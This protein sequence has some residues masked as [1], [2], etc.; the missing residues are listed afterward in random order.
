MPS[1]GSKTAVLDTSPPA[2]DV[3]RR[4]NLPSSLLAS[5]GTSAR[6]GARPQATAGMSRRAAGS[7]TTASRSSSR[8]RR[9]PRKEAACSRAHAR[10]RWRRP[11]RSSPK[12][13]PHPTPLLPPSTRLASTHLVRLP[14]LLATT[15][16]T[17]P[18]P[19]PHLFRLLLPGSRE[20][21][22]AGGRQPPLFQ[23]SILLFCLCSVCV[24][25]PARHYDTRSKKWC[26]FYS[27]RSL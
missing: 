19:P 13:L 18:T 21:G 16:P 5:P 24:P 3:L 4:S 27:P 23:F 14:Y 17:P 22:G 10:Q 15:P 12:P 1:R 11:N 7:T 2:G 25:T 6:E 8:A 26:A 20:A 9:P